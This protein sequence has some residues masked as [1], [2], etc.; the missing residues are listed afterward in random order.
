MEGIK[1]ENPASESEASV[2]VMGASFEKTRDACRKV[3][4]DFDARVSG[5]KVPAEYTPQN[6]R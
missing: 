6:E 2:E 3:C 4:L 5:M 1:F